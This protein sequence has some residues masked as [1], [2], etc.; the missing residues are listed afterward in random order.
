M[1]KVNN[2]SYSY[3]DGQILKNISLTLEKGKFYVIVGPNGCGKTTLI[4]A[5]SRL[6]KP[7]S[8]ELIIDGKS[9]DHF[10]RKE[11][12]EKIALLPQNKTIPNISVVDLISFGRFP[13]HN[14]LRRLNEKDQ[15][16]INNAMLKTNTKM[17]AERS[18]LKLSGGEL[19]R[20]Y[21]AMLFAWDTPYLLLDEPTTH[22]DISVSLDIMKILS[23]MKSENKCVVTVF[24]DLP[25]ALKFAD[26]IIVMSNGKIIAVGTPE[27]ITES[28]VLE[29]VFGV[30]CYKNEI[31]GETHYCF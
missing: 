31:D 3:G 25:L 12:A 18:L 1:I 8:G 29:D 15:Q 14:F 24:H 20:A 19:Q 6:I 23:T 5:I 4:N 30:K 9:Y 28:S 26:E 2:L 10:S 17:L 11:F 27:S 21:I 16:I 7:K 22:L 13:H